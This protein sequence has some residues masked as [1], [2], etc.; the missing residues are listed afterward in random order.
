MKK[1]FGM[2][3]ASGTLFTVIVA[4]LFSLNPAAAAEKTRL[5]IGSA[6]TAGVFY[7]YAGALAN[8]ISK[9]IPNFEATAEATGGSV[10]NIKLIGKKQ[11]D[12]ATVTND[13]VNEAMYDFKN[14]KYFKEKVELRSLFNMYTQPLHIVTLANSSIKSVQ[15]L[16]GKRVVVG[17]PGSG[18]EVKT[19]MALHILGLEYNKDFRPEFLTFAEG[20]EALQ[21]KT[22]DALFMSVALPSPALVSLTLTNP[23]RLIPLSDSEVEKINKAYPFLTKTAIPGK[24]YKGVDEDIQAVSVQSLMVCRADL[25][26]DVAYKI[27]KTVFERKKELEQIHNSFAGTTLKLATPTLIPVHPGAIKYFKEKKVYKEKY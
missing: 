27:V 26:D 10:E 21:D 1:L 18:S 14:S 5:A 19:R 25:P 11:L 7:F 24:T 12:L 6:G 13:V 4:G 3:I 2:M 22:A 9:Y 15:D 20:A 8:I 23:I 17:S 16:K